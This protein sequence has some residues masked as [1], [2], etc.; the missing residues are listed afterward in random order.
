MAV[1]ARNGNGASRQAEMGY[2][3]LSQAMNRLLQDS[4]LL[5]DAFV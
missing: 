2:L 4:Y 3:P 1:L 5:P